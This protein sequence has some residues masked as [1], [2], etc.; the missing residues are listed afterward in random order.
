MVHDHL[1]VSEQELSEL[2][3]DDAALLIASRFHALRNEGC[4]RGTT[5]S[6]PAASARRAFSTRALGGCSSEEMAYPSSGIGSALPASP[7]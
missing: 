3:N 2:H 5:R 7:L 6:N 1:T 4:E